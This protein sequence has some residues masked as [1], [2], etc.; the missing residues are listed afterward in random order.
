ML[1]KNLET[2]STLTDRFQ[3]TVPSVVRQALHLEKKDKIKFT[4]QPNGS[5]LLTRVEA[6]EE[7]PVVESFLSFIADDMREHPEKLQPLTASMRERIESLT[8]DVT[9]DLDTPL[10][11][12]D[13]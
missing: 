13:E 8:A 2:E 11:D 12:E 1:Q 9:L 4:V 6:S 10:L 7:D 3:T 5:V